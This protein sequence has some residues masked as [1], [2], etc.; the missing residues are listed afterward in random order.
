MKPYRVHGNRQI[1]CLYD[2]Q[3]CTDILLLHTRKSTHEAHIIILCMDSSGPTSR[4]AGILAISRHKARVN[5]LFGTGLLRRP[6]VFGVISPAL[7]VT[8]RVLEG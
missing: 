4:V 3:K 8:T 6:D 7:L 1:L 2:N 5:L